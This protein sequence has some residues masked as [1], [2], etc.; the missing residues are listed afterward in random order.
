MLVLKVLIVEDDLMSA[1]MTEETLVGH[2]YE[3]C[4]IA[5]SVGEAVTLG[6]H[7][8]PDLA[9]VDLRLADGGLGTDIVAQLGAVGQLG[10]LYATGDPAQVILTASDGHACLAK[11]FGS[12]ELLRGLEIVADLVS[13]GA[14][15]SP[16]PHGFQ[17][18]YPAPGLRRKS[19]FGWQRFEGA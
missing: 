15:S 3:V 2:G 13:T 16:L 14:A 11:P 5:R 8:K 18:L 6:L 4:G 9:V 1:D 17:V 19:P 7:H 10:V 12:G